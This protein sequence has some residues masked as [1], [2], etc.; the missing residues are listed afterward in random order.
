MPLT[1][2]LH[3]APMIITS[4]QCHMLQIMA[5]VKATCD[6]RRALL[7]PKTP[8]EAAVDAFASYY[9]TQCLQINT[10]DWILFTSETI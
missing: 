9:A 3:A 1:F 6:E 10:E 5:Q 7:A 2:D 4:M 8:H